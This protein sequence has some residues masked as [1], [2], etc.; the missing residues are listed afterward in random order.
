M[1]RPEKIKIQNVDIAA[2]I[3]TA[4]GIEPVLSFG[5]GSGLANFTFPADHCI[6]ETLV[7]YEQQ[8]QLEAKRLL[9]VRNQLFRRLK[10]GR[11]W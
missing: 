7:Q 11:S 2:V 5:D 4:T 6:M 3:Q 1:T 8:L 9:S 10:G